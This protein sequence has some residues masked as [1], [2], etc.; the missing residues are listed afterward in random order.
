MYSINIVEDTVINAEGFR[1][2]SE[3]SYQFH[4]TVKKAELWSKGERDKNGKLTRYNLFCIAYH[5]NKVKQVS[6]KNYNPQYYRSAI[7]ISYDGQLLFL[8]DYEKGII[9][10][11]ISTSCI[12][13]RYNIKHVFSIWVT[14]NSLLCLHKENNRMLTRL[15]YRSNTIVEDKKSNGLYVLPLSAHCILYKKDCEHY[16]LANSDNLSVSMDVT[17]SEWFDVHDDNINISRATVTPEHIE[18][19]YFY[20]DE[21]DNR[22]LLNGKK[23]IPCSC[24]IRNFIN[25]MES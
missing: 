2:I 8:P 17:I 19:E 16:T 25:D 20:T 6:W 11:E 12:F 1:L 9:A 5:D 7:C 10:I 18:V 13:A 24:E 22:K 15:N 3:T 4:P 14:E 23:I 21:T